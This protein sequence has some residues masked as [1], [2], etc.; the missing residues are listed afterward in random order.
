[1]SITDVRLNESLGQ[2]RPVVWIVWM[3]EDGDHPRWKRWCS[4]HAT[5]SSARAQANALASLDLE[6][7]Y[8]VDDEWLQP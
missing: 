4:V 3:L 6:S 1:M 5:E 8:G 7:S 2:S